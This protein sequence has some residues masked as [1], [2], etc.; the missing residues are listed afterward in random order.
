MES[1]NNSAMND[2]ENSGFL[3]EIVVARGTGEGLVLRIDG[4]T[5]SESLTRA[6][7]EYVSS[8]KS[9]ISGSPVIVEWA[10]KRPAAHDEASILD[11]LRKDFGVQIEETRDSSEQLTSQKTGKVVT[12]VTFRSP[13]TENDKS[14]DDDSLSLFNGIKGLG[15]DR[16]GGA[17]P[18]ETSMQNLDSDQAWDDADARV[19]CTTLRS[20]QK[21]E[22]EHTVVILGD[23]NS[24]AE[25]VAGGDIIV[26]GTLRGV[27][28]AGAFDETGGGRFIF[29]LNFQPTQLRIG[30]VISRGG[31]DEKGGAPEVARVDGNLIMVEKYQSRTFPFLRR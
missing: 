3:S 18:F 22:S 17:D 4:R 29:S 16:N 10:G 15:T 31:T 2:E 19:I 26:L 21:V 6:V 13:T 1:D 9:F 20:G 30:S 25:I 12:G 5:R 14:Q 24:G 27:A 23:V 7:S 28:H 11:L 8:R